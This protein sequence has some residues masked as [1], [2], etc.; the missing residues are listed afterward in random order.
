MYFIWSRYK[1]VLSLNH[2]ARHMKNSWCWWKIGGSS[3]IHWHIDKLTEWWRKSVDALKISGNN[4]TY[5][6]AFD[7]I[8]IDLTLLVMWQLY[9]HYINKR[10]KLQI[11]IIQSL[12]PANLQL[13]SALAGIKVIFFFICWSNYAMTLYSMHSVGITWCAR[14]WALEMN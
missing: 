13:Y 7:W 4:C 1:Q 8:A 11:C 2:I 12:V 9:E 6:I 10:F 5:G 3:N 14:T